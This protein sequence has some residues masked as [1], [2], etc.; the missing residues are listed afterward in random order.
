MTESF[1]VHEIVGISYLLYPTYAWALGEPEASLLIVLPFL[2]IVFGVGF[3]LWFFK[4]P[5]GLQ[6][7][8]WRVLVLAAMVLLAVSPTIFLILLIN[9]GANGASGAGVAASFFI[10]IFFP[11]LFIGIILY[12]VVRIQ[13]NE[14]P[15]LSIGKFFG[16]FAM[17]FYTLF[18]V[19]QSYLIGT[20]VLV[21]GLIAYT[22]A[23][24]CD[25]GF[26]YV[27]V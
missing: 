9:A 15:K 20:I 22:V 12:Y 4:I 6:L 11:V 26:K 24:A 13:E 1:T 25:G 3:Y 19:W 17:T 2:F 23:L 18:G 7:K 21:M 8:S 27:L 10:H 16:L 14:I 5:N